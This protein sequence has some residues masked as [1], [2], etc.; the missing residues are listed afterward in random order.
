[1]K[2]EIELAIDESGR[3]VLR[4]R[5]HDK[6]DDLEQKILGIFLESACEKG[7]EIDRTGSFTE[8]AENPRSWEN[9]KIKIKD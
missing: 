8:L 7:I 1:M 3:A 2:A 6:S 5:H 9:Y 4:I